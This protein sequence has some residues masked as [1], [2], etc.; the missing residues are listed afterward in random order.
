M[1]II[2]LNL[3]LI[4]QKFFWYL[5]AS[6]IVLVYFSNLY[7]QP[8]TNDPTF[9]INDAC[10]INGSGGNYVNTTATQQDGKILIGGNFTVFHGL[11]LNRLARL[12][13]D[14]TV[15]QAFDIGTGFN[16]EVFAITIQQDD[17]I[18]VGGNFTEFNGITA[19]YIIRLNPDGTI[20]ASFPTFNST[21]GPNNAVRCIL[22][23]D[24]KIL[25]G[26]DF[27][28][29]SGSK[30]A[31]ARLNLNGTFDNTFNHSVGFA[32]SVK[33]LKLDINGRILAGGTFTNV[34]NISTQSPANRIARL[35]VN[36]G[37]DNSFNIGSTFG[38][39]G[40]FGAVNSI[41]IQND[42]KII[43]G[44]DF[45]Q[46]NGISKNRIVRLNIDGAID[47]SFVTGTGFSSNVNSINIQPD[48]K[49]LVGGSFTLYNGAST[50]RIIRLNP[51]GAIDP[52][53][54]IGSGL[55]NTVNTI[56]LQSDG[57]IIVGGILGA[58]NSMFMAH[59]GRLES[60]GTRDSNF[61]ILYGFDGPVH[62]IAVQTDGKIIL[63]GQFRGYNGFTQNKIVRL[64]PDGQRDSTF[65][66]GTGFSIYAV[67]V[68]SIVIQQDGKILV[69]GDFVEYNGIQKNR[70]VRL[71]PDGSIDGSFNIGTGFNNT[72]STLALQPDGKLFV[73]GNFTEFNGILRNRLV[74]LNE[75]GS[76]DATFDIG[77]GFNSAVAEV[78]LQVDGKIIVGG[79][80]TQYNGIQANRII[81]L[82]SNGSIDNSFNTLGTGFNNAV[83]GIYPQQN[84]K[85][86]VT[87][88]FSNY[89][90]S[91]QIRI[92]R[93]NDDGSLDLTFNTGNGFNDF[94]GDV[95]IQNDDKIVLGGRFTDYNG[96]SVNKIIR[97]NSNGTIDYSFISGNGFGSSTTNAFIN[98]IFEFNG[99][100]IVGG[101]FSK[102]NE[103][104]RNNI[105]R[106][107]GDC[108]GSQSLNTINTCGSYTWIN[109]IT[110]ESSISNVSFTLLN[111]SG[112]DS[113]VSLNLTISDIPSQPL[114][115]IQQLFCS[116]TI[117]DLVVDGT[118]IQWYSS[119]T[120]GTALNT[121]TNLI[122][123]S[124]YFATQTSNG[125]ESE[126]RLAVAVSIVAPSSP[127]GSSN[128]TFC[129]SA[130]VSD[131]IANGSQ[132]QWY[133]SP[134]GGT[135]LITNTNLINN[136]TYYASQTIDGCESQDRL[137]VT[138]SVV[139]TDSPTG[140]STQSF[141]NSATISDLF[142]NGS[143]IQWYS[144]S[145]GGNPLNVNTNLVNNTT[146]YASQ[147]IGDCES[148]DRLAVT[149]ILNSN[150]SS[151][152]TLIGGTLTSNQ[153]GANY[154][155]LNCNNNF[156]PISG[157]N[158]VSF[159]PT[160]TDNYAVEVTQNGCSV[161]SG[162]YFVEVSSV[163]MNDSPDSNEV[164][165]LY[166]NPNNGSFTFE[167]SK[168]GKYILLDGVG[169]QIFEFDVESTKNDVHIPNISKGVYYI[170]YFEEKCNPIKLIVH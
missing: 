7:A 76:I 140:L 108:P 83:R 30:K 84:G 57:K 144:T 80:F 29:W 16:G 61:N 122:N 15:D 63:G 65:V 156:I 28:Q 36:G 93:I 120:G 14:G 130:T 170:M 58:Y 162:C 114:G 9:N 79:G 35:N 169:K 4:N 8:G 62:S 39:Q 72:V 22:V 126:D 37:V 99:Q 38:F 115:D 116:G 50:N 78:N 141:C 160:L 10:G 167:T 70:I 41:G 98:A 143:Q 53:F 51:V 56:S 26:G 134:T 157:A 124:T 149:V 6:W 12:N 68:N 25:V 11:D 17:K 139:A 18:L 1:K 43:V 102:Y 123:N 164:L 13:P 19:Y 101:L 3:I 69:G 142:A 165:N 31:I 85:F 66:T 152:V 5:C 47:N 21:T 112:C 96:I 2:T 60:N 75:D 89:N 87:G 91:V 97:L 168:L 148:Q 40:V 86:I 136:T 110:Y 166:P 138:V 32:G 45:Q 81:R 150:P 125:C 111:S 27:Q 23:E 100:F 135:A 88:E 163:G 151:T 117:S 77:S 109:G 118:Q 107:N 44:G 113:I 49:I 33:V 121:N 95:A 128:Q 127:T 74:R 71:N 67:T 131:L 59:V 46:Y 106:I 103:I 158:Q 137:I 145:T 104:C 24:N 94:I 133:S 20:D 147:T 55:S 42:S 73:S 153:T 82:N 132:I 155:W 119:A 34:V 129:Y 92:A 48:G 161:I 105:A 159:T 64:F 90:G 52:L 54:V 154:Q 146:Y